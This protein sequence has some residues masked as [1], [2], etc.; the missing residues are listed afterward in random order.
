[1]THWLTAQQKVEL[2]A[3]MEHLEAAGNSDSRCGKGL[4]SLPGAVTARILV[5]QLKRRLP[6][7]GHLG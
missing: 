2:F 5:S 6:W 7:L 1:M 4:C 3:R